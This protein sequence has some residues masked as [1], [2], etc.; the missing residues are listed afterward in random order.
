MI[1]SYLAFLF[2]LNI[3]EKKTFFDLHAKPFPFTELAYRLAEWETSVGCNFQIDKI[4]EKEN[5][6][7]E[8]FLITVFEI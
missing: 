4:V 8:N 3:A 6:S 5:K 2:Q 7:F 1:L